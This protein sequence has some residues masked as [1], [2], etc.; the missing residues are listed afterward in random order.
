MSGIAVKRNLPI[1]FSINAMDS[2]SLTHWLESIPVSQPP[3]EYV[4]IAVVIQSK[5]EPVV[6]CKEPQITMHGNVLSSEITQSKGFIYQQEGGVLAS[7][8]DPA[9]LP[10][11]NSDETPLRESIVLTKTTEQVNMLSTVILLTFRTCG[12]QSALRSVCQRV[13]QQ[14]S[15]RGDP[16]EGSSVSA[17]ALISDSP[18]ISHL[19]S[20]EVPLLLASSQDSIQSVESSERRV[21]VLEPRQGLI[22]ERHFDHGVVEETNTRLT[23]ALVGAKIVTEQKKSVVMSS[24]DDARFESEIQISL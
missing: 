15:G 23:F 6:R 3:Q 8:L 20:S 24:F 4:T 7:A 19:T 22:L 18:C 13:I 2:Q 12:D 5:I 1:A 16:V 17:H 11:L 10:L 14:I 21:F 9:F